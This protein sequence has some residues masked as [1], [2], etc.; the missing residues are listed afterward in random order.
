MV[1]PKRLAALAAGL[2]AAAA[3]VEAGLSGAAPHT[4][5]DAARRSR[6]EDSI[7]LFINIFFR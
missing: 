4:G 5:S 6:T 2:A 1:L 7:I 3:L